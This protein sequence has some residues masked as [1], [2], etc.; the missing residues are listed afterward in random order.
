VQRHGPT[1]L[2][3]AFDLAEELRELASLTVPPYG[4]VVKGSPRMSGRDCV[5]RVEVMLV[6]QEVVRVDDGE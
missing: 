5:S 6:E 3:G 1:Q 2:V 4:G